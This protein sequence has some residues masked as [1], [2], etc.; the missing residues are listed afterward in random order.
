MLSSLG[1]SIPAPPCP[2]TASNLT[3]DSHGVA[4]QANFTVSAFRSNVSAKTEIVPV[5]FGH[6]RNQAETVCK[7]SF[8]AV[9]KKNEFRSDS[10]EHPNHYTTEQVT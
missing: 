9:T 5:H 4:V 1:S 8:G 2:P 10:I 7:V 6:N 3:A